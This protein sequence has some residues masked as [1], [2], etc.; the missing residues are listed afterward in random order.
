ML[1]LLLLLLLAAAAAESSSGEDKT[2]TSITRQQQLSKNPCLL[3]GCIAKFLG[4]RK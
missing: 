3:H 2:M 4:G 1:L